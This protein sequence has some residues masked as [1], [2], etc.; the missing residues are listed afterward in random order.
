MI[1]F[2][3]CLTEFELLS[4][5]QQ[6]IFLYTTPLMLVILY[7]YCEKIGSF[8]NQL[9]TQT[10]ELTVPLFNILVNFEELF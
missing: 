6:T 9:T 3:I 5:H 8:Y 2:Q 10:T 7:Q 1:L 4:S